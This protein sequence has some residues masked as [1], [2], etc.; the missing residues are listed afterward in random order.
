M[1]TLWEVMATDPEFETDTLTRVEVGDDTVELGWESK[2]FAYDRNHA[3]DFTPRVG[4]QTVMWGTF[5]RPV[6]GLGIGNRLIY[7]RTEEEQQELHRQQR[8]EKERQDKEAYVK[9]KASNDERI[10]K[11]PEVFQD[12]IQQ[13][14]EYN[15]EW[16]PR[17][18]SYELFVCEQAVILADKLKT[19]EAL[20][21]FHKASW[22]NQKAQIPE[23]SNDHSGNTFGSACSLASIF[24][25]QPELI[26]NMHGAL[27]PLVGCKDYGCYA[28]RIKEEPQVPA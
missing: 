27:C 8:E 13:F 28:A 12:R 23:I 16:G 17:F 7:Y 1:K 19:I 26:P 10:A 9:E 4:M 5:G 24:L 14:R 20:A 18:E 22:E 3:S 25:K 11:L 2:G 21:A 15:P 6:R